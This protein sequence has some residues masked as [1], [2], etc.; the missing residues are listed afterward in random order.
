M[1]NGNFLYF[2]ESDVET[3]GHIDREPEAICFPASAY[4]GTFPRTATSVLVKAEAGGYQYSVI[5]GTN[6]GKN[7][8]VVKAMDSIVYANAS[9]GKMITV[10]D[11]EAGTVKE[12]KINKALQGLVTSC[13]GL[14]C[15]AVGPIE[16]KVSTTAD[17]FGNYGA[18]VVGTSTTQP[19][20]LNYTWRHGSGYITE[21]FI[22]ITGLGSANDAGDAIGL[23][24]GGKAF[25]SV[26]KPQ[27][28]SVVPYKVE[29]TCLVVP[30]SGSNNL[31]DIDLYSNSSANIE[32]DG[33][34]DGAG[35][36][37]LINSGTWTK[38]KTLVQEDNVNDTVLNKPLYLAAGATHSGANTFT[39]GKY[40]V[41]VYWV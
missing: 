30:T 6:T 36:N 12:A 18:G 40:V 34:V 24:A 39:A 29:M 22:D 3:G 27:A 13:A 4:I 2:A 20:P 35:G 8:E 28:S 32:Y 15:R 37:Q 10:Y 38:G 7:K 9:Q 5:M 21:T 16:N 25:F 23:A 17:D 14:S 11:A 33:A 41:R 19:T 1:T 26:G 31:T